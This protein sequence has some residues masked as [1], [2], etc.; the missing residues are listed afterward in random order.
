[1]FRLLE[2]IIRSRSRPDDGLQ[3][4]KHVVLQLK[5]THISCNKLV[6]KSCLIRNLNSYIYFLCSTFPPSYFNTLISTTG[7]THLNNSYAFVRPTC[8]NPFIII[9]RILKHKDLSRNDNK[10]RSPMT[11]FLFL[12]RFSVFCSH[13]Y[14][15]ELHF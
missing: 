7:M 2:A 14:K 1:M 4:P 3:R 13:S 11:Y 10:R 6:C 12:G 8:M 5:F 9:E 15:C